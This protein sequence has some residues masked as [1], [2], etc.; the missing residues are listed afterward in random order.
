M[1]HKAIKR[2]LPKALIVLSIACL[3][4]GLSTRIVPGSVLLRGGKYTAGAVQAGAI[5]D[6]PLSVLNLSWQPI[7]VTT[8]PSC[9]CTIAE[10]TQ[11]PVAPFHIYTVRARVDTEGMKPGPHTRTVGVYLQEGERQWKQEAQISFR[12]L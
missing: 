8:S 2:G 4:Q 12:V 6:C 3:A 7:Q 5:V 10:A 11:V 9:G 1:E